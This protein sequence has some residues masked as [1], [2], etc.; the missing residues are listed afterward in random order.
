MKTSILFV[1]KSKEIL[2]ELIK[3]MVPL[4]GKFDFFFS[5]SGEK[6]LQILANNRIDLVFSDA[7]IILDTG[8]NLLNE[9]KKISPETIRFALVPNLENQTIA[10]ITQFVHQLV[11][12]PYTAENIENRIERTLKL[13]NILKNEKV[14]ELVKNT[15]SLPSLPEIYIQIEQEI[16]KPDFSMTKIS[17]LISK[18]P[19]LTTKVLQI[20]NSAFFGL[21]REITNINFALSY[22][23]INIIK[24]LIFYIHLFSNFKVRGEQKKYLEQ[25]WQHSLIVAS[26]TYKIAQ[27][28]LPNKFEVESSYTIGVLHDVGKF[29][30]LNTYTYPQNVTSHSEKLFVENIDAELE[31][32][33][34]THAEIGA[35]L[36][37][38]WGFPLAIVEG[39]AYHHKPSL[40]EKST[41][42][43]ATAVHIANLMYYIPSI[44]YQHFKELNFEKEFFDIV[45]NFTTLKKITLK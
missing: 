33:G 29:I 43:L 40:F 26:T 4:H 8:A 39:V 24:S 1:V 11:T 36:L 12:P 38:L 28:Y 7:N 10:Q 37:G 23:G 21:Q 13:Q 42:N 14:I 34:C 30:L 22:L 44:D 6:A 15:T 17:N 25:L 35:Y 9:V 18:D 2:T 16:T 5:E 45:C 41:F 31:I 27:K 32:Y 19:N 3:S 20:V